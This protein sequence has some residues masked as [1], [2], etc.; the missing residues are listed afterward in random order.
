M[1]TDVI[2]V[3]GATTATEGRD[4]IVTRWMDAEPRQVYAAWTDPALLVQWFTPPPWSTVRAEMDVRPGGSTL[5]VMR[6]PDGAEAPNRGVYLEVA[7]G[8]R[9]VFTNAYT[10]AWEPAAKA[11][12]TVVLTFEREG[13]GT[14]YTARVRHWTV[15]DREAHEAMGFHAG[16]AIA[17]EQLA[18]LVEGRRAPG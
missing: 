15:E 11:F 3:S 14:R 8:E 4:L 16:W 10:S 17:T 9:L 7:E 1:T 6:G 5:V 18:A 2:A 12:M 13:A